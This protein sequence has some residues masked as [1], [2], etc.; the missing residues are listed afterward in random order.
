MAK[1]DFID[2]DTIKRLFIQGG[3]VLDFSNRTWQEFVYEKLKFDVYLKYGNLSKGR[4]LEAIVNNLIDIEV[5][6]F[7]LELLR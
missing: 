6:K 2:K 5:G 7:I 4:T 3:Y 1:L